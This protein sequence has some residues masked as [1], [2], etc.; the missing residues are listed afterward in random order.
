MIFGTLSREVCTDLQNSV[1]LLL[2]VGEL[3]YV[4]DADTP[5]LERELDRLA[6]FKVNITVIEGSFDLDL[7]GL[8]P[9]ANAGTLMVSAF[10]V[11]PM[12]FNARSGG[13]RHVGEEVEV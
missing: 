6:K 3:I 12:T 10:E 13:W 4:V 8:P 5:E 1:D 11:G 2:T 9:L 7:E